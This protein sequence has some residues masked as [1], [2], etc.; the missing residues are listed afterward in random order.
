MIFDVNERKVLCGYTLF[1]KAYP[2][3]KLY[4]TIV[5]YTIML[6][7]NTQQDLHHVKQIRVERIS[8]RLQRVAY[9]T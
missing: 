9:A 4:K 3:R 2:Y 6:F 7:R 1:A 5:L 8:T